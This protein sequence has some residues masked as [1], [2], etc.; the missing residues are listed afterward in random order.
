MPLDGDRWARWARV[1]IAVRV[2]VRVMRWGRVRRGRALGAVATGKA[3]EAVSYAR[4]ILRGMGIPPAG[5]TFVGTDNKANAL[6]ASR[7]S[8]PTRLRHWRRRY[9]VFLERVKAGE[10]EIG[11]VYD[12]ENPADFMTKFVHKTKAEASNEYASQRPPPRGGARAVGRMR[13]GVSGDTSGQR[14]HEDPAWG[15]TTRSRVGRCRRARAWGR[16]CLRVSALGGVLVPRVGY[17]NGT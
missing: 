1:A 13:R 14:A 4:E 2:G 7:R 17:P 9:L 11:H 10:C 15:A 5:P 6:I 3:G 12:E 8:L 16:T